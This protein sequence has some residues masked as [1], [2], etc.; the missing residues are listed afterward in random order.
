MP[1]SLQ[2]LPPS[3][4]YLPAA[5][6]AFVHTASQVEAMHRA[7]AEVSFSPLLRVPLLKVPVRMVRQ[8]HNAVLGK[9]YG[10]VRLGGVGL[11]SLAGLA[12][13]P[14]PQP[15]P[16][17][18]LQSILNGAFGDTLEAGS[19][20]LAFEM[21]LYAPGATLPL[22][23]TE[24]AEKVARSNGRLCV[25]IHGLALDERCWQGDANI[26]AQLETDFGYAPV[27]LRYNSGLS[28]HTNAAALAMYL[29]ECYADLPAL[30]DLLLLG[31]SMGGLLARSASYLAADAGMA[32]LK[33]LRMVICLGTPHRGAPLERIGRLLTVAMQLSQVSSPLA[34]L[35]EQRSQGVQDLRNGLLDPDSGQTQPLLPGVPYRF[36]AASLLP[37]L[38]HPTAQ[39]LGDGMVP[40]ASAS[41]PG[42]EGD[43]EV[44]Q[45]AGI[46]HMGLLK[47]P[48]VYAVLHAWLDEPATP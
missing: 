13:R 38:Q 5:K 12:W 17:S 39:M 18:R 34:I 35:A 19:N 9:A 20:P 41:D 1:K 21:N 37:S 15:H 42:L 8:V 31:H 48:K 11:L 10:A 4:G 2:S 43:I 40:L 33:S 24:L 22:N 26:G 14:N 30:R 7:I 25:L 3:A 6:A 46:G 28:V 45:L 36:V 16:V 32:W 29:H 23:R 27:Y 47:H 44:V